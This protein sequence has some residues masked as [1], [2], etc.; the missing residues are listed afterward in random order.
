MVSNLQIL[1]IAVPVLVMVVD[2]ATPFLFVRCGVVF[3]NDFA[4]LMAVYLPKLIAHTRGF[5]S[6]ATTAGT[7]GTKGTAATSIMPEDGTV[8]WGST[9]SAKTDDGRSGENGDEE[10]GERQTEHVNPVYLNGSD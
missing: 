2:D 3:L 10:D 9:K 4:V 1:I 7:E 6:G 5:E 8:K